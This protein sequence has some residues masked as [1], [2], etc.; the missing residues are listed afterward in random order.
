MPYLEKMRVHNDL[1]HFPLHKQYKRVPVGYL[2]IMSATRFSQT[3][4]CYL[5][6]IN[7]IQALVDA[8][9]R[10]QKNIKGFHFNLGFS[11]KYFHSGN[12]AEN[13]GDDLLLGKLFVCRLEM[14]SFK[15]TLR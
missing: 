2:S 13:K 9:T 6:C 11:G 3:G 7:L 5:S 1:T 8:Q 12:A 14:F 15:S 10:L 4:G